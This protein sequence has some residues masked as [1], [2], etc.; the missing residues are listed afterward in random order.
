M[1]GTVGCGVH[2]HVEVQSRAEAVQTMSYARR[3]IPFLSALAANSPF[4]RSVDTGFQSYRS[5]LYSRLPT[6]GPPPPVDLDEFDR[7]MSELVRHGAVD[8]AKRV[9]WTVRPSPTFPTVEFRT[10]DALPSAGDVVALATICVGLVNL[11]ATASAPGAPISD[12]YVRCATFDAVRGGRG[13]SSPRDLEVKAF[14]DAFDDALTLLRPHLP[15]G[16]DRLLAEWF[17][18][19]RSEGS[20]ADRQ[21]ASMAAGGMGALREYFRERFLD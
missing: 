7:Q 10:F 17:E 15:H 2:V 20:F 14:P 1:A 16:G 3:W 8:H 4:H 5:V 6:Y 11:A 19:W 13:V 18:H 21:R 9:Y 12:A